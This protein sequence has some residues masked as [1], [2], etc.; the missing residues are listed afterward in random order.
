[1]IIHGMIILENGEW[2]EIDFANELTKFN[3]HTEFAKHYIASSQKLKSLFQEYTKEYEKACLRKNERCIVDPV[4]FLMQYFGFLKIGLKIQ[5]TSRTILFYH[6][7][8]EY[9][10]SK[11]GKGRFSIINTYRA[12][13]FVEEKDFNN[14]IPD[15]VYDMQKDNHFLQSLYSN[16][17]SIR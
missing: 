7:S 11:I 16:P 2:K 17:E 5:E 3:S 6:Q 10:E 1:M 14:E 9:N 12:R 8:P 15:F 4:D 13:G